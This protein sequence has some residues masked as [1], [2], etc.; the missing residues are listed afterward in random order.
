MELFLIYKTLFIKY[1]HE[2]NPSFIGRLRRDFKKDIQFFSFE[3]FSIQNQKYHM[4]SFAGTNNTI[5]HFRLPVT[6]K[7]IPFYKLALVRISSINT[8]DD[9]FLDR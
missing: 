4:I 1:E 9:N 5:S 8:S 2:V 6:M 3:D 7:I